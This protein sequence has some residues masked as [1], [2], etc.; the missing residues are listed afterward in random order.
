M[1]DVRRGGGFSFKELSPCSAKAANRRV[2]SLLLGLGSGVQTRCFKCVSTESTYWAWYF[3][4][5]WK[6]T[7]KLTLNLGLRYELEIP[8]HERYNR[9]N[10]FD[11]NVASP[12]AGPSGLTNL[13]GGLVFAG[14]NGT[15]A[16]Q[17]QADKNNLAPRLGF[18]YQAAER[19]SG[20]VAVFSMRRRC[21][22]RAAR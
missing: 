6:L 5:D 8:R 15:S 1:Y 3:S 9:V 4:D 18:A 12:L 22:P 21:A 17:F 2:A 14:V 11:A 13:K 19:S 16:Q 7:N 20:A 10:V